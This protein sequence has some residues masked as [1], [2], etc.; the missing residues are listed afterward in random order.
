ITSFHETWK[1]INLAPTD[2]NEVRMGI[3][4]GLMAR[5]TQVVSQEDPNRGRTTVCPACNRRIIEF[6]IAGR[7]SLVWPKGVARSPLPPEVPEEYSQEY[8]EA[9]LVLADSPKASAALSR[10]C[11]QRLIRDKAGITRKDLA[12]EIDAL[13][14]SN[15]LPRHVA[16]NVDA[17]RQFGNFAAHPIEDTATG[18]IIDVEAGE[19]EW[20]LEVIETLFDFFLVQPTRLAAK[21]AALNSKL[22]A[23]GKPPMK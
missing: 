7:W 12:K 1:E 18:E 10:R 17:I 13:L 4:G 6:D 23:A 9:C 5:T 19:A 14:A 20:S 15:T 8:R 11:L 16:E 22:A 2:I 3:G 21:K